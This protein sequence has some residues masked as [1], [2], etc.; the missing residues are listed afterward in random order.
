MARRLVEQ[1]VPFVEVGMGG[2]DTH[3]GNFTSLETKLPQMDQAMAALVADLE[4]R[5]LLEDE[6][7]AHTL[8]KQVEFDVAHG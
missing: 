6:V 2:W 1:G 8:A 7:T 5:G 3:A 4:Q